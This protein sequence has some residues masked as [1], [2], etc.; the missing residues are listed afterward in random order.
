MKYNKTIKLKN[1]QTL[2]MRN[3]TPDD[4]EQLLRVFN[5]TH[6]ET[7]YLFTY[8]DENTFTVEQ[9]AEFLEA[10]EKSEREIEIL[11]F[12][13][14]KLVGSSGV[15]SIGSKD[16]V[17][18]RAEFGISVLKEYWGLGIGRALTNAAIECAKAAGYEQFELTA[19]AE[20][21]A[22]LN[23]YKSVGFVEFGRNPRGFKKR[24]GEYQPTVHMLLEL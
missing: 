15:E 16:K 13:D 6:A 19:V 2:E 20:N 12:I 5:E 22:A 24:S 1:G 4:A 8:P 14:G 17:K 11:A 21:E 10:N 23:L 9:E 7:D 18:H 3:G